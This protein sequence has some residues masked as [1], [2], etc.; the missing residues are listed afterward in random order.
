LA[1]E[2]IYRAMH[3]AVWANA[4]L[5]WTCDENGGSYDHLTPAVPVEVDSSDISQG[6][7][8][9]CSRPL[10]ALQ[11]KVTIPLKVDGPR[12]RGQVTLICLES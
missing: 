6:V 4:M 11:P 8:R 3:G 7:S 10:F 2:V 1:A 9:A 12:R 5:I